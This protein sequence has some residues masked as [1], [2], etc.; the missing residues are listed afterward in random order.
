M[1]CSNNETLPDS[2]TRMASPVVK[3]VNM[4]NRSNLKD[5]VVAMVF[6][7]WPGIRKLLLD[8]ATHN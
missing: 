1:Y 5:V 3:S 2:V 4:D 7:L 6:E 8:G